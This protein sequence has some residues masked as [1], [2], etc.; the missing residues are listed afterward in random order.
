[1]KSR[2]L[3]TFLL[4]ITLNA[5]VFGFGKKDDD[6]IKTQNND[7]ILCIT[8][9]DVSKLPPDKIHVS[10]IVSRELV[11][12]LN[13]ISYRT[14]ISHEYTYYEEFAWA[15]ARTAAAKAVAVKMDERSAALYRG[16]PEWRYRKNIAK[17]DGDLAKLRATLDE[18]ESN[19]PLINKEPDFKLTN[20]NIGLTFPAPPSAGGERAFCTGQS[21][22]AFLTGSIVE[23]YGRLLLSVRVYTVYT[24]SFVWEDSIIFS[25]EDIDYAVSEIIQRLVIQLSGNEPAIVEIS[26]EPADTLV[27]IN[28]S[29]AGKGNSISLEMPPSTISVTASAANHE[30]ITFETDVTAEELTKI[31]ISLTPINFANVGITEEAGGRVYQGALFV[32]MAPFTLRLPANQLEYIEMRS[33]GR[34]GS[35]VFE[36]PEMSNVF[37]SYSIKTEEPLPAGRV[38]RDRRTYY[39]VWAATWITGIAAWIAD[40]SY[41]DALLVYSTYPVDQS[42][43]DNLN[44]L[45][46]FRIGA[47]V[48]LGAAGSYGIYRF[49]R[50]LITADKGST[51][52][53]S[54]PV[55]TDQGGN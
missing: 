18:I 27:L 9:F 17:I 46:Y 5:L 1:M 33:R 19:A 30:S 21:A 47:L 44:F 3:L 42:F 34:T 35:I 48:S 55:K 28:R 22:D 51:P 2:I 41:N 31:N 6:E 37:P 24:R 39:W 13:A 36:T 50:Y 20:G 15:R 40:Y 45:R 38:D 8:A 54:Q 11:E 32:G 43:V 4:L 52:L 23:F 53:A 12:R 14:R 25:L 7:W 49:V 10:N 29:F 26:A 16:D